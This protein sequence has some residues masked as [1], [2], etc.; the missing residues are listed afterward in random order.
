MSQVMIPQMK[1]DGNLVPIHFVVG[2][3]SYHYRF[4]CCSELCS[5]IENSSH[6][7]SFELFPGIHV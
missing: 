3:G 5:M 1:N 2:G 4:T 6:E 7:E